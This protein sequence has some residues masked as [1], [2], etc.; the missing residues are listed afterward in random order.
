[1]AK[2]D[3]VLLT[4][5][6]RNSVSHTMARFIDR[7]W[8]V[9]LWP[10]QC[11]IFLFVKLFSLLRNGAKI[12]IVS[13]FIQVNEYSDPLDINLVN[14]C[15]RLC[16]LSQSHRLGIQYWLFLI[17]LMWRSLVLLVSVSLP[18]C[19]PKRKCLGSHYPLWCE[20]PNLALLGIQVHCQLQ[21]LLVT[22]C[23]SR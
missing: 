11:Y 6:A 17:S 14:K 9:I 4:L 2:N 13:N 22:H 1:M 18:P 12:K 20:L 10:S 15:T 3:K 5:V 7:H 16:P 23:F 21:T 19:A 8:M